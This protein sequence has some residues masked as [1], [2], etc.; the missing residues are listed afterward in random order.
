MS[1]RS[2]ALA[3][4]GGSA[5]N[6][7]RNAN[8]YSLATQLSNNANS[9]IGQNYTQNLGLMANEPGQLATAEGTQSNPYQ[10]ALTAGNQ[11]QNQEQNLLNTNYQNA[12]SQATWPYQSISMIQNLLQGASGFGGITKAISGGSRFILDGSSSST[13]W[14]DGLRWLGRG[15]RCIRPRLQRS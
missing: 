15:R 6:N 11:Q 5:Y 10:T 2:S 9:V 12:Y 13:P 14:V 7:A 1:P 8:Q 4:P 3:H